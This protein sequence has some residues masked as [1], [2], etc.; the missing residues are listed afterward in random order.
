LGPGVDLNPD[1]KACVPNDSYGDG[2]EVG[3][4]RKSMTPSPFGVACQWVK[5]K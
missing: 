5:V 4:Y 3:G 2:A 1:V